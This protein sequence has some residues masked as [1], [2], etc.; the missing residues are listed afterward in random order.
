MHR[1]WQLGGSC[2]FLFE[3]LERQSNNKS[4]PSAPNCIFTFIFRI[5]KIRLRVSMS[6]IRGILL[7]SAFLYNSTCTCTVV[8]RIIYVFGNDPLTIMTPT[9]N[10]LSRI[11]RAPG[12]ISTTAKIYCRNKN[13]R[14]N[15]KTIE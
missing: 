1:F 8:H 9:V 6:S 7:L 14:K 12:E 10:M 5:L 11:Y 3:S 15:E 2:I 13:V 4:W